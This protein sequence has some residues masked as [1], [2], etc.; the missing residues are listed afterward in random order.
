MGCCAS[1][2]VGPG[3]NSTETRNKNNEFIE[4]ANVGRSKTK[5]KFSDRNFGQNDKTRIQK[6]SQED[7]EKTLTTD[8][9]IPHNSNNISSDLVA[10]AEDG[11]QTYDRERTGSVEHGQKRKKSMI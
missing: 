7:D 6:E 9:V 10:K 8:E 1:V 11:L 5:E 3:E 2:K 4:R